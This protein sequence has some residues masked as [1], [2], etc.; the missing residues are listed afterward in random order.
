MLL[1]K[2]F[3]TEALSK[4][5]GNVAT[6][7]VIDFQSL[8]AD[9]VEYDKSNC[10]LFRMEVKLGATIITSGIGRYEDSNTVVVIFCG[11]TSKLLDCNDC[12]ATAVVKLPGYGMVMLSPGA[13]VEEWV[14]C[15]KA[16]IEDVQKHTL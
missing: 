1:K 7:K 15:I 3:T 2:T 11:G 12:N 5:D 16:E 9:P 4:F 14:N 10:V 8:P 13:R 6:S